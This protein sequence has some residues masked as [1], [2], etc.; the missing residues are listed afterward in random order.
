MIQGLQDL[1]YA[2]TANKLSEE[3]GYELETQ[4]AAAFRI[5]ILRGDWSEAEALLSSTSPYDEGG[6][7]GIDGPAWNQGE[8]IRPVNRYSTDSQRTLSGLALSEDAN[9]G[10]MLFLI[11]QQKYLELL[12]TRDLG[13]ALMVLRQE[14]QPLHQDERQLHALSRYGTFLDVSSS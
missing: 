10:E 7:V 9:K 14:L 6:G 2:G 3:S 1:G 8:S 13:A 11:R 12:E 5:A 4:Y